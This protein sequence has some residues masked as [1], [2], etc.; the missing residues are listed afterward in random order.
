MAAGDDAPTVPRA[1]VDLAPIADFL[2]STLPFDRLSPAELGDLLTSV[3]ISYHTRGE[4]FDAGSEPRGLRILRSGA[5]D[6]RDTDNILLDRL[7]EG[8]SFHIGGLNAERGEVRACVIED[9]LVYFLPDSAYQALRQ[10]HRDIDRHFSSQRSRRLR[11]AARYQPSPN[12]LL[13]SIRD[14]MNTDL[15]TVRGTDS[16]QAVAHAMTQRRVS[17]ALVLDDNRLQGIITDRDLRAR[18]L[19]A[20]LPADTPIASIMTTQLETVEADCT[21]F[22]ATLLMTQ[23]GYHHLPVMEADRLAGMITTSDLILARQNDPVYLVQ[24][25]S[26]QDSAEGIKAV[27]E[28]MPA[29]VVQW[30]QSGMHAHQVSRVLTAISDAVTVRLIQ[31][32]EAELGPAPAGWCWVGFGSQARAEQLFG[33]DQ[34]NGMI[35]ADDTQPEHAGWFTDLARRVC[36]G[37]QL[38]GYPYCRGE[39]MATTDSWR[40]PLHRWQ[41]TVRGWTITPSPAA[42]MRVSIFFDLRPIYGEESLCEALQEVMLQEASRNSIFLAALAANALESRPPL[43][44]FRR[45]VVERNGEHRDA[46]DVKKRGVLPITEIVR[47]HA[48]AH[49]IPAV[50]TEERLRAL[51]REKKMTMGDSRNLADALHCIQQHRLQHQCQQI[52]AGETPDNFLKPHELPTLARE[53]LRDAFTLID[54]SQAAV[55]QTY[56]A[57]MG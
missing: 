2:A 43:G 53:Q 26:R 25:I 56:R 36:D 3:A 40:Q 15:L 34:D 10:A 32:A 27:L 11:R 54:E 5:V 29:L 49:R 44:M 6:L 9:A 20:A 16:L 18:A 33:A 51:A 21:L 35:L 48:L 37:L 39:I 30:S 13:Q 47:L 45:F 24:H 12:A 8:E 17:S 42:V 52:M 22:D 1:P 46:V 23:R 41:D 50:N 57:G 7:G 55:R 4:S 31:L 28:G 19:T 14:Y 38:C